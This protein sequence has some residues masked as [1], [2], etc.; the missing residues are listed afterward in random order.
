M[1]GG[2]FMEHSYRFRIYPTKEQTIQIQQTFGCC[3]FVYNYY[4]AKRIDAYK[5]DKTT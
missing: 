2:D 4:L 3:R 5:S 1:Q